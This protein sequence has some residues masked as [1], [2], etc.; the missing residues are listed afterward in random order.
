MNE[1]DWQLALDKAVQD[2]S[3]QHRKIINDWCKAYMAEL[4]EAGFELK[5]GNFILNEQDCWEGTK[6]YKKYWFTLKDEPPVYVKFG[7]EEKD[8][9]LT[10]HELHEEYIASKK[11]WDEYKRKEE[12]SNS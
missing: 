5:P 1:D 3:M 2:I 8:H 4:Y 10:K 12:G 6:F 11:I 9:V 7:N